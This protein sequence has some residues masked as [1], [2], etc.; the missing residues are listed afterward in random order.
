MFVSF[1]RE[2]RVV[3]VCISLVLQPCRDSLEQVEPEPSLVPPP[4]LV[5]DIHRVRARR[6]EFLGVIAVR[7]VDAIILH[8][9]RHPD[10]RPLGVERAVLHRVDAELVNT[11]TKIRNGFVI[12][13]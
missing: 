10:L 6:R 3:P 4:D 7:H 9:K 11:E 13:R 1:D 8:S 12:Q 2:F 5:G